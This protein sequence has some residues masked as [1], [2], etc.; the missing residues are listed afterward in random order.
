MRSDSARS[1]FR[2]IASSGG[3]RCSRTGPRKHDQW[4]VLTGV[5]EDRGQQSIADKASSGFPSPT[6]PARIVT[7][8][9]AGSGESMAT[10]GPRI[11]QNAPKSWRE[12]VALSALLDPVADHTQ[13][14]RAGISILA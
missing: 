14:L 11:V 2:K 13:I 3:S 10:I 5:I 12:L 4:H 6:H 9:G 7:R 8:Q 1:L